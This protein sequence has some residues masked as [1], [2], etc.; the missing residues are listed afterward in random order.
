MINR[1]DPR[2]KAAELSE[3]E[4]VGKVVL[5]EDI[6]IGAEELLDTYK[7]ARLW[8][9]LPEQS[10]IEARENYTLRYDPNFQGYPLVFLVYQGDQLVGV[11]EHDT[12]VIHPS[13][14]R[15]HLS[16]EL[17]LA[18]FAQAPWKDLENRQVTESGKRALR[19][20]HAFAARHYGASIKA[21]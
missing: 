12:I 5:Y 6:I 13:H 7:H 10:L 17:I 3:P 16:R 18:G 20:A 4:F 15:K 2:L 19:G 8:K 21:N 1:H 9:N 11:F 14:Q